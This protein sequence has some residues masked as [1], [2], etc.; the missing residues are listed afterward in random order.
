MDKVVY[1]HSIDTI[2]SVIAGI[3]GKLPQAEI[4]RL[5]EIAMEKISDYPLYVSGT[6]NISYEEA[7]VLAMVVFGDFEK[8]ESHDDISG[9]L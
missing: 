8:G 4:K 9:I 5:G 6:D 7:I 2:V 3:V 1:K